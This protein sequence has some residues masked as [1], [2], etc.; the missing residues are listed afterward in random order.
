MGGEGTGGKL[1]SLC[2]FMGEH[3]FNPTVIVLLR[4]VPRSF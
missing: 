3:K 1:R 4:L 2:D